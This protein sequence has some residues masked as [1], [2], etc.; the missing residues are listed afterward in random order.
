MGS[1]DASDGIRG[2]WKLHASKD[3]T[4]LS[5]FISIFYI[6]ISVSAWYEYVLW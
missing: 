3:L 6:T 4:V 5:E 1:Y 2:M